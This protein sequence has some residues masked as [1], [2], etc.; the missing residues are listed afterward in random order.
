M[1]KK[2]FI[3]QLLSFQSHGSG[4]AR[5]SRPS[6]PGARRRGEGRRAH[7]HAAHQQTSYQVDV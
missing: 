3:K 1:T 4:R 6:I 5:A 7:P 2:N